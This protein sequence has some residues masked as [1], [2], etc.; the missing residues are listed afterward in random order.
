MKKWFSGKKKE[1]KDPD[2]QF[3]HKHGKPSAK[4]EK[5]ATEPQNPEEIEKKRVMEQLKALGYI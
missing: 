1:T 4:T 3:S 5:T 2:K